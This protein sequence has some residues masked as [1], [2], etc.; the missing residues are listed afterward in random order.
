MSHP[1]RRS[2]RRRLVIGTGLLLI[3]VTVGG[4]AWIVRQHSFD[5]DTS[6][7]TFTHN[8]YKIVGTLATPRG[9]GPH[10]L[11]VFIHGDGS[12][13]ADGNGGYPMIWES[14]AR[15]GYASLSWDQP[16]VGQSDGDW[17]SYS[18]SDRADL[19]LA[20]LDVVV[21]RLDI[22]SNRIGLWG[23]S[24]AGWVLPKIANRHPGIRF[25][26][27]VSPAI[28]WLDQGRFSELQGL[29]ETGATKVQVAAAVA[30]SNTMISLLKRNATYD[31]YLA[32]AQTTQ[33]S[34]HHEQ[35][36][37][38]QRWRFATINYRSDA[39]ADLAVLQDV[40]VLLQIAGQDRN[41]DVTETEA[42]YRELLGGRLQVRRYPNA[43]HSM[44]RADINE[45]SLR[46]W[47]S[48]LFA[49]RDIYADQFLADGETF[50]DSLPT[51]M[52]A[53]RLSSQKTKKDRALSQPLL[54]AKHKGY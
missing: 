3:L 47:A 13:Q 21:G 46:F 8:G 45:G 23:A 35:P 34:G 42:V 32:R 31:E 52:E 12:M 18:M 54:P 39:R 14:F 27:G 6:E 26:I 49:I 22:D 5:I 15:V 37:S 28:N 36:M 20:A 50:L 16:G 19:A 2:W 33:I 40:P 1:P 43:H 24:Q 38:A 51:R 44:V 4:L 48:A 9:P 53:A 41:V 10:G 25:I 17:E 30:H 7:V 29:T 11:V